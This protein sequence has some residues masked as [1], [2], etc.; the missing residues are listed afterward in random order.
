MIIQFATSFEHKKEAVETIT[1]MLDADG[2]WRVA[3]YFIK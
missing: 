1:P 2:S 3:G